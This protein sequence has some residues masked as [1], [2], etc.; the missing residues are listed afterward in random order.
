MIYYTECNL[1]FRILIH[2]LIKC[3]R[4]YGLIIWCPEYL[5]LLKSIEYQKNTQRFVNGIYTNETFNGTLENRQYM[6][7]RFENCK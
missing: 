1:I 4:L 2:Y 3:F 5:K 7:S 6:N